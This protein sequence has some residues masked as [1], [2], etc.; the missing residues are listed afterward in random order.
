MF[1]PHDPARIRAEDLERLCCDAMRKA[2]VGAE[3]ARMTADVLVTTDTWGVH[4]HGTKQLR[5]L[6]KNFRDG[7]MDIGASAERV[8]EGPSWVLFDGHRSLPTVAAQV[9]MRAAVEKAGATGIAF[10]G[11]SNSGHFGA[12]GYYAVMAAHRGMIGLAMCNVDPC[13][14][15]PGSR[16]PVLGT[17]PISWAVPAPDDRPLFL[18]IATSVVAVGKVA[19]AQ[20]A[21]Q[22]VPEGWLI[23]GDGLPT[24]DPTGYPRRGALLPMGGHKGF[25]IALLVEILTGVLCGGAFGPD[26]VSW[27]HGSVPVNQSLSFAAIDVGAFMPRQQFAQR[28]GRLASSIRGAPRAAGADRILL[29]GDCEWEHRELALR[30]G[31]SLPADVVASVSALADE[32]GLDL[33]RYFRAL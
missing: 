11:I 8:S 3:E 26:V 16:G 24:T 27:V 31:I 28:I 20:A 1:E 30:E 13:V 6:L 7:A 15:V 21:G 14:A 29:P 10:A 33:A 22:R 12:A 19:A 5:G 32:H 23:D 2:G 17:N 18:D 9:A 25:G 4:T